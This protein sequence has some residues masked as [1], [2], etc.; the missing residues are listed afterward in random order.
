M[1]LPNKGR[2]TRRHV[3]ATSHGDK[4][5]SVYR[6]SNK[7]T[8]QSDKS[9]R[10][11]R[12]ILVQLFASTT[13]FVPSRRRRKSDDFKCLHA[14]WREDKSCRGD[15]DLH[16]NSPVRKKQ[17]IKVLPRRVATTCHQECSPLSGISDRQSKQR[18][19]CTK[20]HLMLVYITG[21]V[22]FYCGRLREMR[23]CLET[24]RFDTNSSYEIA[25]KTPSLQA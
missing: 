12:R 19:D 18:H 24:G 25:Q 10:V 1:N 13:G 21:T 17:F 7:S 5:L 11:Y 23:L 4:S 20:T 22:R 9:L 16:K 15:N 6:S 14:T 2:D 8:R 3:A